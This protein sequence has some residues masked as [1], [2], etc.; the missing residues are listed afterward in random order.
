MT[1]DLPVHRNTAAN[2]N[3]S[4][5]SRILGTCWMV[6]GVLRLGMALWM[7]VF[8]TTATLMFGA[9]LTR[10]PD[11]FSLMSDFHFIYFAI[12]L[13]ST[14]DGV[15]AV[16]AGFALLTSQGF[17]R[18]LALIAA[19]LSLPE[20]PLGLTLGAYTLIVLLPAEAADP[21][22]VRFVARPGQFQ[23]Q[24]GRSR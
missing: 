9:L 12:A 1:S 2:I 21:Y 4:A 3:V 8:S 24:S 11:P 15:V 16:F 5:H 14:V 19:F 18:P 23:I 22:V 10:V 6:Y 20:I 17:A 13:W 7:V